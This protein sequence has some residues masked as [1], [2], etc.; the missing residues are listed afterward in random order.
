MFQAYVRRIPRVNL[1]GAI[2]LGRALIAATDLVP[3]LS[4]PVL[5]ARRLLETRLDNLT[6]R[7]W[8][9]DSHPRTDRSPLAMAGRNLDA[10]WMAL[11]DWLEAIAALPAHND[12]ARSAVEILVGIFPDGVDLV[13]PPPLLEWAES[14]ARI[15]RIEKGGL[16]ATLRSLGG[17]PFVGAIQEAHTHYVL[18][19]GNAEGGAWSSRA[20]KH[21]LDGAVLA[22]HA[23]VTCVIAELFDGDPESTHHTC[24]L[25]GPLDV[26]QSQWDVR[27]GFFE[28]TIEAYPPPPP[29]SVA[30]EDT[31]WAQEQVA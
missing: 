30:L 15:A 6:A 3:R 20:I 24:A 10:T 18:T 29:A 7:T 4:E 16:E 31:M 2:A 25:L 1:V 27:A 12:A 19:L 23:Y 26:A 21:C 22:I 28:Q 17:G 5:R 14:E 13:R 11:H 8:G 9:H